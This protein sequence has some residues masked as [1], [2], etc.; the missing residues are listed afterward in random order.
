MDG[1]KFLTP[2]FFCSFSPHFAVT[3]HWPPI[4]SRNEDNNL[5]HNFYHGETKND[6]DDVDDANRVSTFWAAAP[7]SQ[8][9]EKHRSE[10]LLISLV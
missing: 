6:E 9:F 4:M 2:Q 10:L 3:F 7:K 1:Y 8:C 5:N